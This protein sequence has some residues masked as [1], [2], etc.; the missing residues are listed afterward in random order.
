M[1]APQFLGMVYSDSVFI[2]DAPLEF[3]STSLNYGRN[4]LRTAVHRWELSIGLEPD[5]LGAKQSAAKLQAHIAEY[6]HH[7]KFTLPMPQ[8]L[9]LTMPSSA[10][11]ASSGD[12]GSNA[13][14]VS[15]STVVHRG[16]FFTI[17]TDK[18]VYVAF[19]ERRGNGTLS[20]YPALQKA[21]SGNLN[22]APMLTCRYSLDYLKRVGY[23]EGAAINRFTIL[24]EEAP[25]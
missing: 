25:V 6:G 20:V 1:A 22:F 16:T 4:T 23:V 8:H 5:S 11:S 19:K 2:D 14:E 12:A 17:G 13:V 7:G 3:I 15:T 21:A 18:K 9:G 10:V 24:V